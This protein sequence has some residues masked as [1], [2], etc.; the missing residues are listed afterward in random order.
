MQKNINILHLAHRFPYPPDKGDRIRTFHILRFLQQRANVHLACLSDEPT[1]PET[2]NALRDHCERLAVI[3]QGAFTRW[4]NALGAFL[5][6]RTVTEGAFH[7]RTLQQTLGDWGRET[8][9]DAIVV[10]ASGMIPYLQIESLRDIPV[11]IDLVDVDSQ[12]W[13]DYARAKP[14]PWSWLYRTEGRRLR[15]LENRLPP[16][17]KAVILVSEPEAD[18]YR[19]VNTTNNVQAVTNGVDLDYFTEPNPPK[20]EVACVFVGALDYFPNVDA[21]VWFCREVW[22]EI[23]RTHGDAKFYLVGRRPVPAVSALAKIPGVEVIGGVSDVRP[24]LLRSAISVN[25]LRIARGLQNKVLEAMA[26]R[27]AVIAS[28]AATVALRAE[29]NT[30]LLKAD[31]PCEWIEAVSGLLTDADCRRRLGNAGRHF[32]EQNHV[33]DVCLSPLTDLLG[34]ASADN[35]PSDERQHL[36]T[37]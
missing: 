29:H 4:P 32:V 26:M 27:K 10:S 28:P 37:I 8:R 21:A 14:W 12:K 13:L 3:P 1:T 35:R 11:V 23:H 6:G 22:P 16:Q 2:V 5:R 31:S 17:T 18:L 25:P 20:E 9:F 30:H 7:S 33:W 24:Y 34:L 36:V 19:T 15:R